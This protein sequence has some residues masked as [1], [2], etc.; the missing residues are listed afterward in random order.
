[1]GKSDD[2]LRETSDMPGLQGVVETLMRKFRQT[3]FGLMLTPL[4]L[5]CG[6]CMG[7]SLVPGIYIFT[8]VNEHTSHWAQHWHFLALGCALATGY[9]VYGIT[10]IF[11][12]PL[13]NF[14]MPKPKAFRAIWFSLPSI[15]WYIHNALTYIVR[16]TFLELITPTPFNT[17]FYQMMG[18]KI[19]KGTVINTTNISDPCMI[20]LGDYV[21]IGGSAHLFAHYGQ[22]GYL[23]VEPISIGKGTVIGLKAS[24]MGDVQVGENCV[25]KPHVCLLP[26][27]RLADG[28]HV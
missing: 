20:T 26:K 3:F 15:P 28:E 17:L 5:I 24:V 27:T 11:V 1:M 13:V 8:F 7:V 16:Y 2:V 12:V 10:M 4:A 22:K 14:F 21:T 25:V 9:L 18:M 6:F 23:I 19:G